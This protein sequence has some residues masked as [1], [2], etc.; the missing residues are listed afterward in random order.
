ML[1]LGAVAED[2][3]HLSVITLNWDCKADNVV[4]DLNHV[5]VVLGHVG[6]GGS[7][8][9]EEFD[10]FKETGLTVL[11]KTVTCSSSKR[12]AS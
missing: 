10:L 7:A 3:L 6:L 8:V 4:T 12:T 2:L 9:E 1:V 5:Q 11:I